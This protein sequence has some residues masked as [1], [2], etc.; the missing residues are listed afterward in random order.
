MTGTVKNL[1]RFSSILLAVAMFLGLMVAGCSDSDRDGAKITPLQSNQ[2]V[3]NILRPVAARNTDSSAQSYRIW[4][5]DAQGAL[6]D[7]GT[8]AVNPLAFHAEALAGAQ[9]Y[10][11]DGDYHVCT[12]NI[13][14][15]AKKGIREFRIDYV[16]DT[17]S[18]VVGSAFI[19]LPEEL[20]GNAKFTEDKEFAFIPSS[21]LSR[22]I[23]IFV[24]RDEKDVTELGAGES[25]SVVG[26]LMVDTQNDGLFVQPVDEIELSESVA[27]EVATLDGPVD[28]VYTLLAGAVAEATPVE[29][30]ASVAGA[31]ATATVTVLP[32]GEIVFS[33]ADVTE[34]SE[35]LELSE[36]AVEGA[37]TVREFKAWQKDA[38]DGGFEYVELNRADVEAELINADAPEA[39][40][41]AVLA[42]DAWT[43]TAGTEAESLE[44]VAKASATL[45]SRLAVNV[46][47]VAS[48]TLVFSDLDVDT[49]TEDAELDSLIGDD[50]GLIEFKVWRKHIDEGA[51]PIYTL[52]ERSAAEGSVED[53][54]ICTLNS[55][56]WSLLTL[57]SIGGDTT[58][59]V[60]LTDEPDVVGTISVSVAIGTT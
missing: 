13:A 19:A 9:K 23:A 26:L 42:D 15:I 12:W 27:P 40:V 54:A 5:L 6:A 20:S 44:L 59:N 29:L 55:D 32:A 36:L 37:G 38:V 45:E 34:M 24:T 52:V 53:E 14:D 49:M 8:G 1:T 43:I 30:V 22:K 35:D 57:G 16:N 28:D 10:D 47:V 21:D 50:L 33:E 46:T 60:N 51:D 7:L 3:F 58:L 56:E 31:T 18:E 4:A 39:E 11:V 41:L 48:D 25:A 17:T 2:V